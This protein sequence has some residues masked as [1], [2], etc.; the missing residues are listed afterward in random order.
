MCAGSPLTID[1]RVERTGRRLAEIET[2]LYY[3]CAEALVN[4]HRHARTDRASVELT[5]ADDV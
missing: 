3:V 4:A 1:L 2:A 5:R